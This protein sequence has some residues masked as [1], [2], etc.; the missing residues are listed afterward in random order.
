MSIVPPALAP[1]QTVSTTNVPT[2]DGLLARLF[3]L[4]VYRRSFLKY[5]VVLTA[6]L[7][8]PPSFAP[9]VA[10]AVAAADKP[11]M[12]YLAF[13]DCT[14]N[15]ESCLLYTSPSPRSRMTEAMSG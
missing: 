12:V 6:T 11:S 13:Q 1:S 9:R 14:G 2:D 3:E 4:G 5:C 7:A 15:A 8:L 10:A